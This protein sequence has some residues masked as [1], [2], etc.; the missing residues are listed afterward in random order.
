MESRVNAMRRLSVTS[1]EDQR[2]AVGVIAD[3]VRGL[4]NGVPGGEPQTRARA[5]WHRLPRQTVGCFGSHRRPEPVR[6]APK[7]LPTH[8]GALA[9]AML[10]PFGCG[11]HDGPMAP[12]P[13]ATG[14]VVT[15]PSE[16][17]LF[18]GDQVQFEANLV[19]SDGSTQAAENITWTSDATAVATVSASGLVT[20]LAAGEAS[21]SAEVADG[22]GG[23]VRIRV[24][25]PVRRALGG[26]R[27]RHRLQRDRRCAV[28]RALRGVPRE[29]PGRTSGRGRLRPDP[30]GRRHRRRRRSGSGP[31]AGGQVGRGQR[32]RHVAPGIRPVPVRHGRYGANR[33]GAVLADP[34]RHAGKHDRR[35]STRLLPRVVD[36]ISGGRHHA[37]GSH[38]DRRRGQ[39]TGRGT[40]TRRS[41]RDLAPE[42]DEMEPSPAAG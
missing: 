27:G 23:S 17:T 29:R 4:P 21:I 5:G 25:S 37:R 40:A 16:R 18:I 11:T 36:R 38:A 15:W 20:A 41:S 33:R 39:L 10:L 14:V 9:A 8:T 7:F 12:T 19:L 22:R 6:P 26:P 35:L 28:E 13:T 1:V 3:R 30:V 42:T 24:F 34:G 2:V 32:R 31:R